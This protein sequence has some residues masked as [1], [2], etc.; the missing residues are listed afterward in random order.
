MGRYWTVY[1]LKI[2]FVA[3]LLL[4][5]LLV[6][7]WWQVNIPSFY[8]SPYL[9]NSISLSWTKWKQTS[10]TMGALGLK[11]Q[12]PLFNMQ[13][14]LYLETY[15]LLQRQNSLPIYL[16]LQFHL[17]DHCCLGKIFGLLFV[18]ELLSKNLE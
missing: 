11:L 14:H 10:G 9:H 18:V 7:S 16:K 2:K 8:D 3:K 15:C 13:N 6:T 12:G 1:C 4:A 17:L 5:L